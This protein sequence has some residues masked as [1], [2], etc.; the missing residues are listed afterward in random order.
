MINNDLLI[1]IGCEELPPKSLKKLGESLGASLEAG[2]KDARFT[3]TNFKWFASPRRLAVLV[4][5]LSEKQADITLVKKGPPVQAAYDKDGNPT[6]AALGWAKSNGIT[7]EQAQIIETPKGKWLQVEVSEQGKNIDSCLQELLTNAI[8]KLPIAKMMRWGDTNHQFVRPVHNLCCLYGNDVLPI[9][10]LGNEAN[11]QV[12]GHRF[13]STGL[14][15]IKSA[16]S[17]PQMLTGLNV[18][19]DFDERKNQ[20]ESLI[21]EQADR[22]D[23]TVSYDNDLLEE[24]SSLVEWPVLL[25][26]KFDKQF[27]EVPKEPL[28]YTMKDDQKYFP[29]LNKDTGELLNSFYVIS[30][31]DSSNKQVVIE[32][33]QK[34]VRPRLADAQFFFQQDL[35]TKIDTRLNSLKNVVYQQQ[36][37]TLY[38]KSLRIARLSKALSLTLSLGNV[39]QVYRAGEICKSDLT[40]KMVYEFP[41]VQGDMGTYYALHEGEDQEVANAIKDHYK[42]KNADDSL[43]VGDVSQVVALAEKLDTLVGIFGIG[44]LPK[45]DKDPFALRRAVLGIIKILLANDIKLNFDHAIDLGIQQYDEGV[46]TNGNLKSDLLSFFNNRL[47]NLLVEQGYSVNL[48]RSVLLSKYSHLTEVKGKLEALA[49]FISNNKEVVDSLV[50]SNKRIANILR[51]SGNIQIS[52]DIDR[53]LLEVNEEQALYAQLNSVNFSSENSGITYADR[54]LNLAQLKD[55]INAFFD[56]VMVNAE[57]EKV[58]QNRIGLLSQLRSQFLVVADFS[59]IQG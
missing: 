6:K 10:L 59:L 50:A 54:L 7:L 52:E 25:K 13:H 30:N 42:P 39:R 29:L 41:E 8:A 49:E 37:G 23:A 24:V 35:K 14:H 4:T 32:G 22:D 34:V 16:S 2:L 19:A 57:D 17:Y 3:Y 1:E 55:P 56:N 9:T 12:L 51:K 26:A 20:I 11:N 28:I 58:R 38:D 31:I 21:R 48:I 53:G 5:E 18:I 43:P 40:S 33:N 36:L 15:Q 46:L 44:Q 45:G 47:E 27:L